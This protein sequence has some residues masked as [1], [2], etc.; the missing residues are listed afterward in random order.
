MEN[1]EKVLDLNKT[2]YD[3]TQEYPEVKDIMAELG[4]QDITKPMALNLMGRVMTIPKGSQ[5]KGI[6]M[7]RIEK[8]FEENGY[9]DKDESNT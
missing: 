9:I 3:L 6:P 5:I 7:E 8:A 4:F 1:T 2:V